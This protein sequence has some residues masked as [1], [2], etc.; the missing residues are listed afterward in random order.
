MQV[1]QDWEAFEL[2]SVSDSSD[3]CVYGMQPAWN[4]E[5]SLVAPTDLAAECLNLE[6]FVA[7]PVS[8]PFVC[9][10]AVSSLRPSKVV[11]NEPS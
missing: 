7:E 6:A 3:L 1:H 2:I 10:V 4:L 11:C 8:G 9:G 5:G